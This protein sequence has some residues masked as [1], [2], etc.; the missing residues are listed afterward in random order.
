MCVRDWD[1]CC[2]WRNDLVTC[3]WTQFFLLLIVMKSFK[4]KFFYFLLF[5]SYCAIV[6]K[7][8]I[9]FSF[10]T[11]RM[12]FFYFYNFIFNLNSTI[13]FFFNFIYICLCSVFFFALFWVENY[14]TWE[15]SE[16]FSE[17]CIFFPTDFP[18]DV[19]KEKD[20]RNFNFLRK[21]FLL[22]LR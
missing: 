8:A 22:I 1:M 3:F 4:E 12:H 20:R 21:L 2:C 9:L 14:E 7:F 13:L 5:L 15:L 6:N 17:N 18:Y 19:R 10:L 11:F 16:N